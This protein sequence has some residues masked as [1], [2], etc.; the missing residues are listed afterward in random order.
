MSRH[1]SDRLILAA[2]QRTPSDPVSFV[3]VALL[4]TAMAFIASHL[5][6][7]RAMMVDPIVALRSE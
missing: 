7:R 4:L 1:A 2:R 5:P 3:G 6:V